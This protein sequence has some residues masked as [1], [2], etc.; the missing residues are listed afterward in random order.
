[1]LCRYMDPGN[2]ATDLEGGAKY[3]YTLLFV[4]FLSN[5]MAVVLQH[6]ALKLGVAA[7]KDLAQVWTPCACSTRGFPHLTSTSSV[8]SVLLPS[9]DLEGLE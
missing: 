4:V 5:L 2:W 7:G 1:M 6:L 8:F 3:E 9:L